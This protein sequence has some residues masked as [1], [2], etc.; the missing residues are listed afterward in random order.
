MSYDVTNVFLHAVDKG[1]VEEV[2]ETLEKHYE[3][4]LQFQHPNIR[5]TV[6]DNLLG[7]NPTEIMFLRLCRHTLDLQPTT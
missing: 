1:K 6:S 2:L 5:G 7:V 3:S 4:H